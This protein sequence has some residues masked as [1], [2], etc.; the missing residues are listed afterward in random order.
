[1]ETGDTASDM[2]AQQRDAPESTNYNLRWS[3]R[4]G[5][6]PQCP[7]HMTEHPAVNGLPN[8]QAYPDRRPPERLL[9]TRGWQKD[10]PES[11]AGTNAAAGDSCRRLS[12][13]RSL[14]L[15]LK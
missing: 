11:P 2:K 10:L 12:C 5:T 9:W 7:H 6:F 13:R 1:M 15:T 8:A 4:S 14:S 3:W